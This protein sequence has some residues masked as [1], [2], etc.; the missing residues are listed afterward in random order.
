MRTTFPL[1]RSHI[2]LA[3]FWLKK[4]LKPADTVIDATVGNGHDTCFLAT[5]VGEKGAIH[6]IDI[7]QKALQNAQKKAKKELTPQQQ[8]VIQWYCQSHI[9]LPCI[10][11]EV[12]AII[13]NLGYLPGSDKELTTKTETTLQS[14]RLALQRID[15]EGIIVV[16]C[17]PGHPEGKKE[18]SAI[19]EWSTNLCPKNWNPT[20][21][22]FVNRKN[23]PAL[24]L[25]QKTLS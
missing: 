19:Y 2:D 13:Y 17:Y 11:G 10:L 22:T 14:L 15:S 6:A 20:W 16:T 25:L 5:L 23:S 3:H 21:H 1:F 24:F 8:A 4:H 12:Q 9:D 18:Y 7:Q